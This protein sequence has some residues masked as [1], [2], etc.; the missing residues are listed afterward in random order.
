MDQTTVKYQQGI[1]LTIKMVNCGMYVVQRGFNGLHISLLYE[2]VK[3]I[4]LHMWFSLMVQ[5]YVF[6]LRYL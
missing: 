4:W 2:I 3:A 6:M 5:R 1:E